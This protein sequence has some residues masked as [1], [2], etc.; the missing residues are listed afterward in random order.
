[1][2]NDKKRG[3][4]RNPASAA[5][6]LLKREHRG[7]RPRTTFTVRL[8]DTLVV[9]RQTLGALDPF[10]K[11]EFA[12]VVGVSTE[13]LEIQVGDDIIVLRYPDDA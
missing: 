9:E 2:S 7:G 13:E 4:W 5:N 12:R 10:H 11:P 3:G 1:M 6:G 8:G